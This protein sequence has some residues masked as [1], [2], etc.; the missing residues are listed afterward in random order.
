MTYQNRHECKF[1]VT[2]RVAAEVLRSVRPHVEPDPFAATQ[3]DHSYE[4]ASLYLDD[5]FDSLY[6]ETVD[7]RSERYKL[8]VRSYGTDHTRPE[9]TVFLEV[10]RRHNSIVRKLRCSV[11]HSS[12]EGLLLG[13][14]M[15]RDDVLAHLS[16]SLIHI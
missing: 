14:N 12:L 9:R 7:G 15:T 5:P 2:E 6:H 3:P 13:S 1:V 11:P 4:I 8:R 16:L 10:K